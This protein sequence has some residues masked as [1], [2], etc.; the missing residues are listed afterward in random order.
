MSHPSVT[1]RMF[2]TLV[3]DVLFKVYHLYFKTNYI[4]GGRGGMNTRRKSSKLYE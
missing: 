3:C 2:T 1:R 4:F